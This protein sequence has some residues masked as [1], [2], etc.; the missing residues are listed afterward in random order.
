MMEQELGALFLVVA[1]LVL[2]MLGPRL[3]R[4]VDEYKNKAERLEGR[5]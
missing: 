4:A 1:G 2:I 3:R 5:R